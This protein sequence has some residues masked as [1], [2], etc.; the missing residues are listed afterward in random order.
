MCRVIEYC[1]EQLNVKPG[2]R[3]TCELRNSFRQNILIL[4]I[5]NDKRLSMCALAFGA[6]DSLLAIGVCEWV[7]RYDSNNTLFSFCVV[8]RDARTHTII[9][10][11]ICRNVLA[12]TSSAHANEFHP[13]RNAIA[14]YRCR[15]LHCYRQLMGT[16]W[17]CEHSIPSSD[18]TN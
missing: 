6:I 15:R 12:R 11:F 13:L 10:R 5:I 18:K 9:Y 8:R 4:Q 7:C 17:M 16:V 3:F 14:H 1:F 2:Q